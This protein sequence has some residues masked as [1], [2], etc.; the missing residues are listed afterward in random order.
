MNALHIFAAI[1]ILYAL[2]CLATAL[3]KPVAIWRTGK[4]QGFVQLL[5]ERGTV[6]L[7]N[8]AGLIA[9]VAGIMLLLR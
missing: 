6:I 8:A 7:L 4:L 5:G 3:A 1:L 9:L 2:L